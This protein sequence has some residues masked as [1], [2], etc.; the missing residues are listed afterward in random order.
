MCAQACLGSWCLGSWLLLCLCSTVLLTQL[1]DS[2]ARSTRSAD[3]LCVSSSSVWWWCDVVAN[4]VNVQH[5]TSPGLHDDGTGGRWA[6][7]TVD[8]E[9]ALMPSARHG[10][11]LT[12]SVRAWHDGV[13]RA[14]V[15]LHRQGSGRALEPGGAAHVLRCAAWV[16]VSQP[17]L[18]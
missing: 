18:G 4:G 5:A 17:E 2:R 9:V 8:F 7:R 3:H 16:L 12:L 10:A 1:R 14:T 13:A 6:E 11:N 15:S